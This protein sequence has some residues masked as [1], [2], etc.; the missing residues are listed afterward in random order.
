MTLGEVLS[1]VPGVPA[2]L[3]AEM[4]QMAQ[5]LV[6]TL[7]DMARCLVELRLRYLALDRAGATVS[8]GER[9]RA[10]LAH[11]VRNRTTVTPA[12]S[13]GEAQRLK[14]V[15]HLRRDQSDASWCSTSRAW[16]CTC[17]TSAPS[18]SC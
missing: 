7:V 8:T 17:S 11:A 2:G 13:G 10:Q 15:S 5:G 12:L 4:Q 14:L 3:P 1:W 9:Q 16:A 6:D 18:W